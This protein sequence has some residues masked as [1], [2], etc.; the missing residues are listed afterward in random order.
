MKCS[1]SYGVQDCLNCLKFAKSSGPIDIEYYRRIVKSLYSID[2]VSLTES[3][4]SVSFK[5]RYI[6]TTL[7]IKQEKFHLLTMVS[8]H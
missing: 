3:K 5:F 8:G 2:G 6:H 4:Y 7:Q 1:S